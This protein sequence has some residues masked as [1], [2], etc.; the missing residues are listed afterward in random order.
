MTLTALVNN[1]GH[2][3]KECDE[4][5]TKGTPEKFQKITMNPHFSWNISQV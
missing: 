4:K 1:F 3:R 5:L 2:S